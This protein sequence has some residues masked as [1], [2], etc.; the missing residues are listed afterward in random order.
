MIHRY[1]ASNFG[2]WRLAPQTAG[3][4]MVANRDEVL[5]AALQ[6]SEDDRWMIASQLF[7]TLPDDFAGLSEDDP[8]FMEELDRRADNP[9]KCISASEFWKQ[10]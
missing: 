9:G 1:H 6:L 3:M 4:N 10:E 8:G 5:A 7:D 2:I